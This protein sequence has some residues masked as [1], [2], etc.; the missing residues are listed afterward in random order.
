V[1]GKAQIVTFNLHTKPRR[2][3]GRK[4]S[5]NPD[6]LAVGASQ[7]PTLETLSL[8]EELPTVVTAGTPRETAGMGPLRYLCTPEDIT[9]GRVQAQALAA[10][11]LGSVNN[12]SNT[13]TTGSASQSVQF[14]GIDP[15]VHWIREVQSAQPPHLCP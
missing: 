13:S 7:G 5:S 12:S 11:R 15:E 14:I 2:Q 8:S 4:R 6:D 3:G 10:I 9:G 1:D